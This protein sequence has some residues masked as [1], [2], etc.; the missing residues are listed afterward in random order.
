VQFQSLHVKVVGLDS[1]CTARQVEGGP[2]PCLGYE[3]L[4]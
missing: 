4:F 3:E 1:G 2:P